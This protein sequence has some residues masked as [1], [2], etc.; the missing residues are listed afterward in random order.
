[1]GC[2]RRT[3]RQTPFERALADTPLSDSHK[4][5]LIERYVPLVVGMESQTF[6]VAILFHSSRSVITV[7]SLIVPALLSIQYTN[8]N[9]PDSHMY[10]LTWILSLLVTVCNGLLTLF[11][12]DKYYYHL[13]TVREQLISDGW[14]FLELTGKYS[15]FHTPLHTPTHDNQFIFFCQSVEKIRMRHV[16]EEYYKVTDTSQQHSAQNSQGAVPQSTAISIIP[17]SPLQGDLAKVPPEIRKAIE[18]LS[19]VS[20][21]DGVKGGTAAA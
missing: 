2:C 12:L 3:P 14:Q 8:G 19:H 6:R 21:E 7:G 5:I 16:Q 18:E 9:T 11:K 4:R 13:H 17:P 1:M 10:W 15:G 20:E